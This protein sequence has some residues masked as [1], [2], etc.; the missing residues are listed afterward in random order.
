MLFIILGF[1]I[2]TGITLYFTFKIPNN[3]AGDYLF[4]SFLAIFFGAM[5]AGVGLVPAAIIGANVQGTC[6]ITQK[7]QLVDLFDNT[8]PQGHF[9]LGSGY[10][11]QRLTFFYF[12]KQD[13]YITYHQTTFAYIYEDNPEIP[14]VVIS[15]Y[16]LP[17]P[18]FLGR[19]WPGEWFAITSGDWQ[20][21]TD[22]HVPSKTVMNNYRVG[23]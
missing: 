21:S 8:G 6:T 7:E 23:Q 9:Y 20:C 15:Q 22:F 16:H 17:S 10:V 14:Y 5:G 18:N 11:N 1:L 13:G 19:K 2:A 3:D 12:T 4:G